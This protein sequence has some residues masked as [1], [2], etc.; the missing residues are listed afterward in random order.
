MT[1]G[2]RPLLIALALAALGT[3][4]L[5]TAMAQERKP[6]R[7]VIFSRSAGSAQGLQALRD[8]LRALGQIEGQSYVFESRHADGDNARFNELALEVVRSKPDLILATH[9]RAAALAKAATSTI[10]IVF[11]AVDPVAEGLV[12]SLAR[13]GGNA[14]GVGSR[15]NE[16]ASKRLALLRDVVPSLKLVAVLHTGVAGSNSQ[17]EAYQAAA[18]VLKMEILPLLVPTDAEIGPAILRAVQ[19]RAQAIAHISAPMFSRERDL[20]VALAA[21]H[22]MPMISEG[23]AFVDAGGLMA[24][25]NHG[26]QM[27]VRV[28]SI[29][30]RILRGVRPADIPV[31]LPRQFSFQINLRTAGALGLT[32]PKAVLLQADRVID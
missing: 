29:I 13:P 10:P 17:L 30:D 21:K 26:G 2:R 3:S 27:L 28:A 32:V 16:L 15:E 4:S 6:A 19:Q 14:T 24:Y 11:N 9:G 22:R 12:A 5:R 18:A 31:E 23:R 8:A 25:G 20:T 1:A 7:I